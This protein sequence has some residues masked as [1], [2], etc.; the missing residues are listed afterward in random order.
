MSTNNEKRKNTDDNNNTNQ[1]KKRSTGKPKY[2]EIGGLDLNDH[3]PNDIDHEISTNLDEKFSEN[4]SSSIQIAQRNREEHNQVSA[5]NAWISE[6][7][8]LSLIEFMNTTISYLID[9]V[10][11]L[12]EQVRQMDKSSE[13]KLNFDRCNMKEEDLPLLHKCDLFQLPINDR[14]ELERLEKELH[15][16]QSFKIFFVC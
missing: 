5:S 4:P 15:S 6:P 16:D 13:L 8:I 2:N 7:E 11:S 1:S 9:K 3:F 12:A 10:Q 14:V